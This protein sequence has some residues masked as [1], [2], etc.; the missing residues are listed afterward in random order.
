MI[1]KRTA[2]GAR[3]LEGRIGRQWHGESNGHT[4]DS[5]CAGRKTFEANM[6]RDV[7]CEK[8]RLAALELRAVDFEART[9]RSILVRE[10]VIRSINQINQSHQRA[11]TA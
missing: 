11:R 6:I 8:R 5:C 7:M 9:R 10:Y 2:V 3:P 1:S 4:L